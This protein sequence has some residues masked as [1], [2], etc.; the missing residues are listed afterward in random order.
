M[1]KNPHHKSDV[2][3]DKYWPK[4]NDN[5]FLTFTLRNIRTTEDYNGMLKRSLP[6]LLKTLHKC[7]NYRLTIE[8][9]NKGI[10]HYHVLI[11]VINH[12]MLKI[13]LNKWNKVQGYVDVKMVDNP[14]G[15]FIYLRKDSDI[16]L[17]LMYGQKLSLCCECVNMYKVITN[18]TYKSFL[19]VFNRMQMSISQI[20]RDNE[21]LAFIN[22]KK[23]STLKFEDYFI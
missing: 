23:Y 5:R 13:L 19:K 6:I 4:L 3:R 9:T 12:V 20:K 21:Y 14:L 22:S 7:G 1:N 11:K 10:V 18:S 17:K 2:I 16:L 15:Y 8:L